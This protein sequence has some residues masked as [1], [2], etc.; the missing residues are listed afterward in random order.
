MTTDP[1]PAPAVAGPVELLGEPAVAV[2]PSLVE[3][4]RTRPTGDP[5]LHMMAHEAADELERLQAAEAD[6]HMA[7]RMKCDEETKAQAVEIE[8]LTAALKTANGQAEHFERE[9]YLRGDELERLRMDLENTRAEAVL[10]V[11]AARAEGSERRIHL[12]GELQALRNHVAHWRRSGIDAEA[13]DRAASAL[14][15]WA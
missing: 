2:A 1:T 8:R 12:A 5:Y 13:L 3:R 10:A 4:L 14:L 15:A 11:S 7:Y 9:W 6:F